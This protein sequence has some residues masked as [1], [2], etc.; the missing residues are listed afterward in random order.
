VLAVVFGFVAALSQLGKDRRGPQE[1]LEAR[2][3]KGQISE[4]EYLRSLA[5]L[6]HGTDFVL[7]S[8]RS[9]PE[10]RPTDT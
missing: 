1:Q 6:Q 8:D 2:F 3:A 9:P 10:T 4:A 5:I 7:E